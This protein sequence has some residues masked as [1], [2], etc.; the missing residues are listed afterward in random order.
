M[1]SRITILSSISIVALAACATPQENPYYKYSSKYQGGATSTVTQAGSVIQ[2]APVSYETVSY[3]A[4]QTPRYTQA[5]HECLKKE[6]NRELLGAGLGG[7]IGA[8][9]GKELIG[10]TKGTVIG[11]GLGGAAGYGIGDK[12]VN[13]DP[14]PTPVQQYS[15]QPLQTYT[16][17]P[18]NASTQQVYTAAPAVTAS[19]QAPV[20]PEYSA[21]VISETYV[22]PTDTGFNSISEMGTPG[23]QVLQA[24]TAEIYE[25]P[26]VTQTVSQPVSGAQQ[27]SYNYEANTVLASADTIAIP[28]ETRVFVGSSYGSHLVK[29]GDTV[30]SLSRN[31]CVGI[32]DIQSIN[33][34]DASYGIKIG[35][36]LRLPASNC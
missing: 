30:Y 20:T 31:L 28:Q 13:C 1:L 4:T 18:T 12:L 15:A 24:Q 19:Y 23:Y 11:A 14:Q 3:E 5:N 2:T 17:A 7:T 32:A 21:P 25:V 33:N 35:D 36:T 6:Q 10:G 29:Q 16:T 26:T 9:A 8:I 34:L 27:V 22:S